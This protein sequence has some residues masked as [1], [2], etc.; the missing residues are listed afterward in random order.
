MEVSRSTILF[1]LAENE[2][3]TAQWPESG[4]G[5][6]FSL[7]SYKYE[8]IT[9]RTSLDGYF[10]ALWRCLSVAYSTA[11]TENPR[12]LMAWIRFFVV[13]PKEK[14][15]MKN[16]KLSL[17]CYVCFLDVVVV[18]VPFYVFRSTIK[19]QHEKFL[20]LKNKTKHERNC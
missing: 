3:T 15:Q 13:V 5:S 6:S 19:N 8:T 2:E 7:R 14:K 1:L 16:P 10:K 12:L 11:K 9:A 20:D 18:V 4:C 17:F